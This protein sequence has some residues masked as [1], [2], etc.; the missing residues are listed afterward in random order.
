MLRIVPIRRTSWPTLVNTGLRDSS[1]GLPLGKSLTQILCSLVPPFPQ[2][3]SCGYVVAQSGLVPLLERSLGFALLETAEAKPWA[4]LHIELSG[5]MPDRSSASQFSFARI[6][7]GKDERFG[8]RLSPPKA[9]RGLL[10]FYLIGILSASDLPPY[11]GFSACPKGLA[12]NVSLANVI[13]ACRARHTG[14]DPQP[15]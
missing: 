14:L 13:P 2:V 10:C 5:S 7:L 15:V 6:R 4:I 3:G 8:H 9:Q 11:V 1:T 12:G